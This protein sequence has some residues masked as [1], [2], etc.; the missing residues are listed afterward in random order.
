MTNP[1]SRRAV[2]TA[3][4]AGAGAIVLAGCASDSKQASPAAASSSP[5]G[6]SPRAA[7]P[8]AKVADI[9]V[10]GAVAA[11]GANGAA[12]IVAQPTAGT[13]VAFSA[14]CTHM[15]CTVAP[16]GKKLNCPCHGSVYEAATGKV[17]QGP[18]PRPLAKVDVHVVGG[19]VLPGTA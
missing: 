7:T 19:E 1:V 6:S 13:V 17:L 18:A 5:A 10:G 9:P 12:L 8:L 3:G 16:A 4:A 15:G 2:L 14:K 11:K